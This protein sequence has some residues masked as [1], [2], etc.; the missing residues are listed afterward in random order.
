MGDRRRTV[1]RVT[2]PV[3][4][5]M[6]VRKDRKLERKAEMEFMQAR[7]TDGAKCRGCVVSVKMSS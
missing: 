4:K 3:L 1:Q 7:M 6:E 5:V 2:L